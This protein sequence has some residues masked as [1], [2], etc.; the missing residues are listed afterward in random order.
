MWEPQINQGLVRF[1]DPRPGATERDH[2]E[3]TDA[4]TN[5]V[6]AS[7]EALFSNTS[8]RGKRCMRVSV[9][10]WQTNGQDVARAVAAV[11]RAL[12]ERNRGDKLPR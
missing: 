1:L 5:A 7:G 12:R 8:W 9:C 10:N 4:V 11:D 3:R 6:L 2:D